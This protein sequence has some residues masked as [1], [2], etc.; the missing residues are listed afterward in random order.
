MG[1]ARSKRLAEPKVVYHHTS[2]L[3]TNQIWMSGVI[4]VEG[5]P[6]RALHP[7]LGEVSAAPSLRR[8]F[9]D[10][11]RLAWFTTR[12]EVPNCLVRYKL[13]V[14]DRKTGERIEEHD[15]GG[16]L[17]HGLALNRVAL[18]FPLAATGLVKWSEHPGYA[19]AEGRALNEDARAVG[20]D[21]D[22]WYVSE[23]PIDVLTLSEFWISASLLEPKLHRIDSQL[24]E[25]HKMVTLC[26]TRKGV[27]I[28]PSWMT[29]SE[30]E[31]LARQWGL[32]VAPPLT[33]RVH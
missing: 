21:P 24:A 6:R 1:Q 5:K 17:S 16:E 10:F 23:Q 3:W 26:R 9:E 4:D 13:V 29:R 15:V 27:V 25:I 2:L 30:S 33:M 20:D 31:Q 28:P 32:P 19:T 14:A 22:D 8:G 7:V 11:P 12:I 18:G